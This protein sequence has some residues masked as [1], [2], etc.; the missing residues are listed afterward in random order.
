MKK[1]K[2]HGFTLI[3][4]MVAIM[5]FAIISVLAYRTISTLVTTKQVVTKAQDKWGSLANAIFRIDNAWNRAVP[6]VIR[7]GS[8]NILPAVLGQNK[9]NTSYDAQLEITENGYIGDEVYGSTPPKRIGFRFVD[10]KL[11]LVTWPVLN[12]VL[13]TRP[14]LNLLLDNVAD[15]KVTYFYP[16]RN[17]R[18][19]WPGDI[20]N[21][22]NIPP[23]MKVDI[24]MKSGDEIIRQ[25]AL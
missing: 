20:S 9:L 16:D 13:T 10:G 17:W 4:L 23:G 11:Y 6:L 7:D 2:V 14:Q 3:E 21:I 1:Y 19:T 22:A 8:G 25:W 24:K 12:R 15:F 5:I 18:D